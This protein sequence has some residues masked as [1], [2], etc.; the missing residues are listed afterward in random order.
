MSECMSRDLEDRLDDDL[1]FGEDV[2]KIIHLFER[3]REQL[4]NH[5]DVYWDEC[6]GDSANLS[7][8]WYWKWFDAFY[9]EE[10]I[11]KLEE[12]ISNAKELLKR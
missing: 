7:R 2:P 3:A 1:G 8:R 10:D 11:K 6:D 4:E 12:S 5:L 9:E